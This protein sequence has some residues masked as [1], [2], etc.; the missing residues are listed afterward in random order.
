M[1]RKVIEFPWSS[2]G[3][4]E[5]LPLEDQV[6]RG[7]DKALNLVEHDP[8]LRAV[9]SVIDRIPVMPQKQIKT[10]LG[11]Y[12]TPEFYIPKIL[13]ARMNDRQRE[14]FKAAVLS[15]V[16]TLLCAIPGVGDVAEPIG[17]GLED[18]AYAKIMDTLT[19]EEAEFYK[20]YD[21]VDP[22]SGVA[23]IR[24]MVRTQKER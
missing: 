15:D 14:A 23:M 17:H 16:G 19:P 22:L 6:T 4:P 21:K 20:S 3:L 10:P 11:T 9:N 24:T 2:I 18:T 13:P 7:V 12:K 1:A 8:I 5:K